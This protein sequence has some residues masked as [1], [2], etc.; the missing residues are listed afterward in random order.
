MGEKVFSTADDPPK[1]IG[2]YRIEAIL[3]APQK[4]NEFRKAQELQDEVLST[5]VKIFMSQNA[6]EMNVKD[7]ELEENTE[8]GIP[9]EGGQRRRPASPMQKVIS[10]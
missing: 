5:G 3:I 10:T 1:I 9:L 7:G 4:L 2:N 8:E 6:R